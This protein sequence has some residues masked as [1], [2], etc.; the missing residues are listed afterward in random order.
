MLAESIKDSM[1]IFWEFIRADKEEASGVLKS[2][3]GYLGDILS[4]SDSQLLLNVRTCLEK[5]V[6]YVVVLF[7]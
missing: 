3:Q 6:L 4:P 2:G 5:V 7:H 1:Q